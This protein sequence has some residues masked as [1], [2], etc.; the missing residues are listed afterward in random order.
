MQFS[1]SVECSHHLS[2]DPFCVAL[3]NFWLILWKLYEGTCVISEFYLYVCKYGISKFLCAVILCPFAQFWKV[4]GLLKHSLLLSQ[5][6]IYMY[7]YTGYMFWI[8]T[9]VRSVVFSVLFASTSTPNPDVHAKF[10]AYFANWL[11]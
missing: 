4:T 7:Q 11:R 6:Y 3:Q 1:L 8:C 5:S 2:S 9:C 10:M